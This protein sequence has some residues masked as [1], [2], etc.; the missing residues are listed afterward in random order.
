MPN[1]VMV[2]V[3]RQPSHNLVY[4]DVSLFNRRGS[5]TARGVRRIN[6]ALADFDQAWTLS[7]SQLCDRPP[8][9]GVAG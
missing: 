7:S 8:L 4:V 3:D 6:S 1:N 5:L 2:W 9:Y